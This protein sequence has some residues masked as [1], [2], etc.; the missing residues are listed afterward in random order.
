MV[1]LKPSTKSLARPADLQDMQ[2]DAVGVHIWLPKKGD[3]GSWQKRTE[4]GDV[5]RSPDCRFDLGKQDLVPAE[6][7]H[8]S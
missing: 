4:N 3:G 6:A 7:S 8:L 5:N 2:L 1:S